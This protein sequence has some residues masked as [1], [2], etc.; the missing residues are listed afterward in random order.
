MLVKV[1]IHY[2]PTVSGIYDVDCPEVMQNLKDLDW[3]GYLYH[4]EEGEAITIQCVKRD[5]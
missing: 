2:C 4:L 3:E 5:D 1:T